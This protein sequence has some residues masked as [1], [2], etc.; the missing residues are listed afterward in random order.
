MKNDVHF[1]M[2]TFGRGRRR[3]N[4]RESLSAREVAWLIYGFLVAFGMTKCL[5]QQ[6]CYMPITKSRSWRTCVAY[7][8]LEHGMHNRK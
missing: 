6:G 7:K 4:L 2:A 1:W 8:V 3:C 5:T